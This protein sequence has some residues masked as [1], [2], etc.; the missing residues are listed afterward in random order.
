[1]MRIYSRI[2]VIL[3]LSC[4]CLSSHAYAAD[5]KLKILHYPRIV[6]PGQTAFVK[7]MWYNKYYKQDYKLIVQLENWDVDPGICVVTDVNE[8][9]KNG[10]TRIPIEIPRNIPP[11]TKCRFIAAFL[12][13]EK[14][15]GNAIGPVAETPKEVS[16]QP[17]IKINNYPKNL[18]PGDIAKVR[19]SWMPFP[20]RNNYRL[21]VQLENWDV[22]PQICLKKQFEPA[23]LAGNKTVQ[24]K[25]PQDIK[26]AENCKFVAAF[27]SKRDGWDDCWG[28]VFSKNDVRILPVEK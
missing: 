8:F 16:V 28:P 15:W 21:V 23:D 26:P 4:I 10:K 13:K 27:I 18:R 12:D 19:V 25:I 1:M 17:V 5:V 9:R 14:G 2:L 20:N 3:S 22:D 6:V 24:L 7:V 11:A